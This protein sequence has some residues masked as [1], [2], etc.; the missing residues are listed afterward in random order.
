MKY[1]IIP[2]NRKALEIN[3]DTNLYGS[4]AEIGG[5]QEV[6][7]HFFQAGGA[8]NTVAKSISAYDKRF[9]DS[10]YN[11]NKPGRH[12]S[13]Q[14]LEKMLNYEYEEVTSLLCDTEVD[15]TFFALANTFEVL[16]YAKTNISHGWMG[17]KYQLSPKSEP[18]TVIIHVQLLENDSLLQQQTIGVVGVNLLYACKFHYNNPN[19]FLQ[20]LIENLSMDR[21]RITMIR[22]KGPELDYINNKQLAIQLVKNKMTHAVMFDKDGN[23][24]HPSDMLYKKNVLALR[25]RFL[26]VTHI[27]TDILE[28]SMQLFSDDEDYEPGNT[29]SFCE[30]SINN[31]VSKDEIDDDDFLTRVEMLM[32]IGQNVMISDIPEYYKLVEF[33]TQFK[34]KKLRL[35]IGMPT[36]EKVLNKKYYTKLKGGI[37]EAMGKLFPNNMKLYIYPT[38]KIDNNETLTT[39]HLDL[40]EDVALIFNYLVQN[41]FILNLNSDMSSPNDY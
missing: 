26:P 1:E 39:D 8:S 24:Q 13:E 41:K 20:S 38:K 16:N 22:M 40:D 37:L 33:F 18:N 2:T 28:K 30:L 3:I 12:V 27:A 19:K 17:V 10:F 5:G 29:L 35:V 21:L 7:R 15:N 23:I 14:R 34:L 32:S 36:F 25:G 11:N 6:A 31:I 9:S 4:F